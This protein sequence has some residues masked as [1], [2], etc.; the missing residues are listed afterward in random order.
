MWRPIV[1]VNMTI[2]TILFD[3]DGVVQYPPA[4]RRAMF[5]ELLGGRDDAVDGF[6][7][8]LS[9]V[10]RACYQGQGDFRAGLPDLLGQWN[11]AGSADDLLRAWTAIQVDAEVARLIAA[12]RASGVLCCLATNQEP[13]RRRHM[14]E[15]L[16]YGALFDRQFYSCDLGVAKPDPRYFD[17]ILE[18]LSRPPQEVL[19][20]DDIEANT[21]AAASI[22]I[23]TETF[24]P[25]S[26]TRPADEMRRVLGRYD[27]SGS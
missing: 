14:S 26:G 6:V 27:L 1:S 25:R 24:T 9:G 11:C 21:Q 10:E 13:L 16:D 3:A 8:A 19:F 18:R 22:G 7:R 4:N 5:A 15:T 12:V 20:I 2:S 23:H 17:A